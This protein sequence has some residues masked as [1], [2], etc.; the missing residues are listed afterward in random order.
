MYET[1]N[2][3]KINHM[4]IIISL[5]DQAQNEVLYFVYYICIHS[6]EEFADMLIGIKDQTSYIIQLFR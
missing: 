4:K 6:N 3:N 5:A 1:I 2:Y